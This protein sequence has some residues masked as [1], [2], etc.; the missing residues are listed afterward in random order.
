M[1]LLACFDG[2]Q[3]SKR[4]YQQR[5]PRCAVERLDILEPPNRIQAQT[6]Y[7]Y[8]LQLGH[9]IVSFGCDINGP[10]LGCLKRF[11]GAG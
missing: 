2:N 10:E 11:G 3:H 5:P 9:I 6:D 1:G 7:K 8:P 4:P